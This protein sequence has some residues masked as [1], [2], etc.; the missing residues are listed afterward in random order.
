VSLSELS[1]FL[2]LAVGWRDEFRLLTSGLPEDGESV[3]AGGSCL[4]EPACL[5]RGH[6]EIRQCHSLAARV[7]EVA[8]DGD[9]VLAG[10]DAAT[11][12]WWQNRASGPARAAAALRR[13]PGRDTTAAAG[14]PKAPPPR[15]GAA[16]RPGTPH[17]PTA[18]SGRRLRGDPDDTG[19]AA[20]ERQSYV[21]N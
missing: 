1:E 10:N 13:Q 12:A 21:P 14:R 6:S 15:P 8:E 19:T 18:A 16:G 9:G 5:L 3:L 20:L 2:V 11:A 17:R 4:V 7:A